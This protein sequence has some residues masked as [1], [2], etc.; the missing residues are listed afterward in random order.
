MGALGFVAGA[1]IALVLRDGFDTRAAVIGGV[2]GAVLG[3]H[4]GS[5][6]NRSDPPCRESS[7]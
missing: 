5:D 4:V 2:V 6:A 3:S 1:G 7:R